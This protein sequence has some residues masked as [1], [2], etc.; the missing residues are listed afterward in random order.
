M[1]DLSGLKLNS[2]R[3]KAFRAKN[4]LS[5]FIKQA[6]PLVEPGTPYK[7]NWHIDAISEHLE[8]VTRRDIKRLI[9]N[10]PPRHMKSLATSVFWPTWVWLNKPDEKWMFASYSLQLSIRDTRKSR[11]IIES[12]WYRRN[13]GDIFRLRDDQ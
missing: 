11:Q 7:S 8:A 3:I 1:S 5:E 9:I 2:E 12:G 10:M 4:D 13:Y 6:W